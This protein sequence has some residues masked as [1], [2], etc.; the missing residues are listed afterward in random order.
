VQQFEVNVLATLFLF[1]FRNVQILVTKLTLLLL[2]PRSARNL[3]KVEHGEDEVFVNLYGHL[4]HQECKVLDVKHAIG[5]ILDSCDGGLE[6]WMSFHFFS[7]LGYNT[8]IEDKR[9]DASIELIVNLNPFDGGGN[10]LI[11]RR[12]LVGQ[13]NIA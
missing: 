7:S 3:C 6:D 1:G 9:E 13:I 5:V 11:Q 12:I 8:G 4:L 10:S 2:G